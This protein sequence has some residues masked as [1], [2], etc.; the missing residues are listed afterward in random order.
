MGA[1]GNSVAPDGRLQEPFALL[2]LGW[3]LLLLGE[4]GLGLVVSLVRRA[5][6]KPVTR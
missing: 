3:T 1:R 2:P 6:H 5:L 4:L